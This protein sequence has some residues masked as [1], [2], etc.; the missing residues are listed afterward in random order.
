MGDVAVGPGSVFIFGRA[1]RIK[2]ALLGQ[3]DEWLLGVF[4]LPDSSL[5]RRDLLKTPGP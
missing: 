3:Q 2:E 1:C 5:G 4:S